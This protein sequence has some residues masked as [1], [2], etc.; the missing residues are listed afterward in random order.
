MPQRVI[1]APLSVLALPV[2]TDGEPCPLGPSAGFRQ[3]IPFVL[4][5]AL[6]FTILILGL[7]DRP[8]VRGWMMKGEKDRPGTE[9]P[10]RI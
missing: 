1:S 7:A 8:Q 2:L 9:P 6:H 5:A 10:P 3:D 4:H